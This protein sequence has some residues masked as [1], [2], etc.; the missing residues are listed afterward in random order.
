[1]NRVKEKCLN[2]SFS[3]IFDN[4]GLNTRKNCIFV[5]AAIALKSVFF[6]FPQSLPLVTRYRTIFENSVFAEI[7]HIVAKICSPILLAKIQNF[8]KPAK[9]LI[10]LL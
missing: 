10:T 4:L 2:F 9:K 5:F 7:I 6:Q 1:V 8:A 3:V